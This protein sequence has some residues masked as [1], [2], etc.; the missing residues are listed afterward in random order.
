MQCQ[1]IEKYETILPSRTDGWRLRLS[2][3]L[4]YLR[5]G[6]PKLELGAMSD[7]MKRDMGFMDGR[8]PRQDSDLTR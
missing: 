4:H 1:S 8:D 2:K 7:Y 3:A 5:P 6:Y